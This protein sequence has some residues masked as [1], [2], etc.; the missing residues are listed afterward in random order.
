MRESLEKVVGAA[1]VEA[2]D[3]GFVVR[4]TAATEISQLAKLGTVRVG[5]GDFALD[6]SRMNNVLHLDE[7][8]L[9]VTAQTGITLGALEAELGH[10]GLTLGVLPEASLGRT[11]GAA[12]AAPRPSEASPRAG[13]LIGA[14][15]SLSGVLPD[16]TEIVTR[17]APR[18]AVGP[19]LMYALLGA[20]GAT[21]I[22]TDATLRVLRRGEQRA[23]ASWR[24]PQ[25]SAA[26]S[27]ARRLLINGA[28][29]ADLVV[30]AA[31]PTLTLAFEGPPAV[32][33]GERAEAHRL[34]LAASGSA[35]P[36]SPPPAASAEAAH[37]GFDA[38]VDGPTQWTGW[39]LFGCA[40]HGTTATVEAS[41]I[42]AELARALGRQS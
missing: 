2:R 21:G 26:L 34:S 19:D 39:S 37:V 30:V 17:T 7:T 20:R 18:K 29:P 16:G 9:L 3:R 28:R 1:N 11:L 38:L 27:V 13:R 6:L 15:V 24:F 36:F 14:V 4:P 33:E 23:Q 22:I 10:R 40:A 41:P 35:V 5:G 42:V 12:L 32:V 31:P 8:S 25:A